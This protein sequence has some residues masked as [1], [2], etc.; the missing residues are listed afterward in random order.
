MNSCKR[1]FPFLYGFQPLR[2]KDPSAS[3]GLKTD[4]RRKDWIPLHT[5]GKITTKELAQ[6]AM[7]RPEKLSG[8]L[9][10]VSYREGSKT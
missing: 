8:L 9:N 1:R 5:C 7:K 4:S 2:I 10:T 3:V 6:A